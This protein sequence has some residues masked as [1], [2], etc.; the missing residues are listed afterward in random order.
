MGN[1]KKIPSVISYSLSQNGEQQWGADLS[2]NAVAMVHTKLSLDVVDIATELDMI[3][4]ALDGMQNLDFAYIRDTSGAPKYPR[5]SPEKIV[6]DYLTNVFQYLL[7]AVANF[8][9]VLR[10][11]IPVD[12]VATIPAVSS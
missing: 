11:Q 12:I 3:L 4:Q 1:H 6:E 5:K 10:E 2:P 9:Q 8:T 7:K